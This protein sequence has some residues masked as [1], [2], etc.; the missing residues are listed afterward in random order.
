MGCQEATVDKSQIL[1]N[2]G[3]NGKAYEREQ[4]YIEAVARYEADAREGKYGLDQWRR[5]RL[6]EMNCAAGDPKMGNEN[7]EKASALC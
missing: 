6:G 7:E 3:G 2:F 1:R 4:I 5:K